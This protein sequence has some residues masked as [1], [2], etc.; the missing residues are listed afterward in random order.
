[1]A[2]VPIIKISIYAVARNVKL[3]NYDSEA[4][5]SGKVDF[6]LKIA[7]NTIDLI[8]IILIF[9]KMAVATLSCHEYGRPFTAA[10]IALTSFFAA[11]PQ[12]AIKSSLTKRLRP[13]CQKLVSL[14]IYGR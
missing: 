2:P 5:Q 8:W 11:M 10:K 4:S 6:I 7:Y 13:F 3:T 1:M 12:A 9:D 14:L